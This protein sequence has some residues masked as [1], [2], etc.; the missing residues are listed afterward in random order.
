MSETNTSGTLGTNTESGTNGQEGAN[1]GSGQRT[2]TQE[3]VNT[4]IQSRLAKLKTQA[5]TEANAAYEK[6]FAEL[7]A[8]ELSLLTREKLTERGM[9]LEL[10]GVI[11]CTDEKDLESKLDVLQKT[12]SGQKDGSGTKPEQHTGFNI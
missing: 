3:Q 10:A 4:I 9:P 12:Y 6:K 11:S 1:S 7:R 5:E 8:K 2:F